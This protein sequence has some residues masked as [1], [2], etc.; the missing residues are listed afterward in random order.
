MAFESMIVYLF[1]D[2][3]VIDERYL[4]INISDVNH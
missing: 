1:K 4:N 2:E 3:A